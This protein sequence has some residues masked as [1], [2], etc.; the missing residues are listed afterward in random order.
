MPFQGDR[1]QELD[2]SGGPATTKNSGDYKGDNRGHQ[3]VSLGFRIQ[4]IFV[5]FKV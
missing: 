5:G 3:Q 2:R 1:V 4:F